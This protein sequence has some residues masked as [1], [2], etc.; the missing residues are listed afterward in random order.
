MQKIYTTAI[1][2][3]GNIAGI[4]GKSDKGNP[5][6]HA[7]C[8]DKN[9][10]TELKALVDIDDQA[11]EGFS[12]KWKI[13]KSYLDL[14]EMLEEINP[15]IVSICT[16][17]KTHLSI[18]EKLVKKDVKGII[19]EKP[20][21]DN[22]EDARHIARLTK[23]KP[24]MAINYFRRWNRSFFELKKEL[25]KGLIGQINNLTIHYSKGL[26]SNGSH[27]V[28]L[29]EW[30]FN[31][32]SE[33]KIEKTYEVI[34][35]DRGINFSMKFPGN[36]DSVFIHLPNVN[37]VFIEIN[38]FGSEGRIEITQRGQ[39]INIYTKKKDKNYLIF[40]KLE[41]F[42][43]IKTDWDNCLQ[44]EINELINTIEGNASV[45]CSSEDALSTME[46]CHSIYRN[47]KSLD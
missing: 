4:Y 24:I 14:D 36:I 37:Y 38:I 31:S 20:L 29:L 25:N 7:G 21:S 28:N 40:N 45:S 12:K 16:P 17:P 33:I 46:I 23:D 42:K 27:L 47:A 32:P 8:F 22:I 41:L 9:N 34:E 35:N 26:L 39:E 10:R 15:D 5:L 3:C 11:L 30:F 18:I 2:G 43:T 13:K 44:A 6:S 19:C 1:V